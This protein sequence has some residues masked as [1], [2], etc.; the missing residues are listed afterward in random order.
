MHE[1][2]AFIR[3]ELLERVIG[4]LRH[5]PDLPGVTTSTV[6]GHGR[7]QSHTGVE[8]AEVSMVKLET[9]VPD[10]LLDQVLNTIQKAARTGRTGDGMVFVLPVEAAVRIRSGEAGPAVL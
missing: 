4:E 5:I 10:R 3:P 9:V 6:R 7:R 2:K 1:V 8:F